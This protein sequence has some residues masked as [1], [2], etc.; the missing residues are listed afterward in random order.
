MATFQG[1]KMQ[2]SVVAQNLWLLCFFYFM[3]QMNIPNH[4]QQGFSKGL[5]W[6]SKKKKKTRYI[7]EIL[8]RNRAM[9]SI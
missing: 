9:S 1:Y 3:G 8:L 6:K 4:L 5:K 7:Q 2:G